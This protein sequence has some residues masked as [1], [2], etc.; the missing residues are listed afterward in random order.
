M[1]DWVSLGLSLISVGAIV[2]A[3]LTWLESR[4]H[5]K[6]LE[7]MVKTLPFI[8]RPRR[9]PT[10]KKEPKPQKPTIP[11]LVPAVSPLPDPIKTAAEER[12]RLKLELEREKI[13]WQKSKDIAKA[14][15]WVLDRMDEGEDEYDDE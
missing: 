4:K 15:A 2:F 7:T 3:A 14:I 5:R 6:L 10:K 13:Q 12:K 1:V 11:S 8:A 9:K